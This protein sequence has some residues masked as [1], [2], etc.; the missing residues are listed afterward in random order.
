[1]PALIQLRIVKIRLAIRNEFTGNILKLMELPLPHGY[2]VCIQN[3]IAV[4]SPRRL[5]KAGKNGV[6]AH[7]K[8]MVVMQAREIRIG[9]AWSCGHNKASSSPE[10]VL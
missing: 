1:M 9:Q 5:R 8:L 10:A 3:R 4:R 6:D 7:A 2:P